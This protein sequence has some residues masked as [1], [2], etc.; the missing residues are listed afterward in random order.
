MKHAFLAAFLALSLVSCATNTREQGLVDRAVNA[1][2][3]AERITA[4]KTISV[5]ANVKHWEPEQSDAPGGDARFAAESTVEIVQDRSHRASRTDW[6]KNF[7][8]PAPRTFT[9]SEIV[10]PDAGCVLGIDT[11]GRNAQNLKMNP[12]A[13]A[14]SG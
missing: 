11:N 2:G 3:G 12:P 7:A 13:H 5:K 4:I 6:V 10:T 9:F 14:M 8:Y 1:L